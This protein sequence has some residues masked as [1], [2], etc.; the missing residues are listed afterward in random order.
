MSPRQWATATNEYNAH[1]EALAKS[2]KLPF[3]PKNPCALM[4]KLGEIEPKI[5]D[6][7]M[8]KDFQCKSLFWLH[9]LGFPY[10]SCAAKSNSE[11]FWTKH[12]NAVPLAKPGFGEVT[13]SQDGK[14]TVEYSRHPCNFLLTASITEAQACDMLTM[15][16]NH[17]PGRT[18]EQP[19]E[20]QAGLLL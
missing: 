2:S 8:R 11:V 17:V 7:L 12:C 9:F 15:P 18:S 4:D 1:L 10:C 5:C 13:A 16:H 3:I 19:L 6:R 20:P 14:K